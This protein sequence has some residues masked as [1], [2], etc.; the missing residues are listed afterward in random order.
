MD[1]FRNH[2]GGSATHSLPF[3]ADV[4]P[5]SRRRVT[6]HRDTNAAGPDTSLAL[7]LLREISASAYLMEPDGRITQVNPSGLVQLGVAS[8]GDLQGRYLWD[9]WPDASREALDTAL[10]DVRDGEEAELSLR[11]PAQGGGRADCRVRLLPI[12]DGEGSVSKILA[13]ARPV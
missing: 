3:D 6:M 1:D 11:C 4:M 12:E 5:R 9:L 13:I 2:D 8:H 7:A 10:D